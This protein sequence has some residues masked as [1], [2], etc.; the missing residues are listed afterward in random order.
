MPDRNMTESQKK[1]LSNNFEWTWFGVSLFLFIYRRKP[2]NW[3]ASLTRLDGWS[4][5]VTSD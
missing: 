3:S 2:I 5:K 4:E 1:V